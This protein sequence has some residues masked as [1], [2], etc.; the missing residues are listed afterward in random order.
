MMVRWNKRW[1]Y[2]REKGGG[3]EHPD[4]GMKCY[5]ATYKKSSSSK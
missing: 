4:R 2:T 1:K 5:L 3:Q